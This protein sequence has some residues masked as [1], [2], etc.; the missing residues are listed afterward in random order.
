LILVDKTIYKKQYHCPDFQLKDIL[1]MDH[2]KQTIDFF[3]MDMTMSRGPK[4]KT[5]QTG[6]LGETRDYVFR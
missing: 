6:V 5:L 3:H 2:T 1:N 4:I